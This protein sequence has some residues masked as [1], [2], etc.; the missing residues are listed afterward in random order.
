MESLSKCDRATARRARNR[1]FPPLATLTAPCSALKCSNVDVAVAID[2]R[3]LQMIEAIGKVH[4]LD[5]RAVALRLGP[6]A[7]AELLLARQIA[8]LR[9]QIDG[10]ARPQIAPDLLDVRAEGV[11]QLFVQGHVPARRGSAPT[12]CPPRPGVSRPS[13]VTRAVLWTALEVAESPLAVE[14]LQRAANVGQRI[15]E[16]AVAD[17]TSV[18]PTSRCWCIGSAGLFAP[19]PHVEVH[20]PRGSSERTTS[21]VLLGQGR[22]SASSNWMSSPWA[23]NQPVAPP[24]RMGHLGRQADR[25]ASAVGRQLHRQHDRPSHRRVPLPCSSR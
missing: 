19:H 16:L 11:A 4:R 23:S 21:A 12:R 22:I 7:H 8:N 15:G 18:Q 2:Q 17:P 13:H 25:P 3:A 5:R 9:R 14:H 20:R 6:H 24:K 10:A 1:S